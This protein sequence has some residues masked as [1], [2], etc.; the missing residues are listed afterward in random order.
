ML[1]CLSITQLNLY[2]GTYLFATYHH[3]IINNALAHPI[4]T[5]GSP[6]YSSGRNEIP[7]EWLRGGGGVMA[8]QKHTS[9]L[10]RLKPYT[11]IL[12]K[13]FKLYFIWR[14]CH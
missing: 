6:H 3:T 14:Q 9:E 12:H 10:G 5:E 7:I 4:S 1:P 11:F 8:A 2:D 13:L